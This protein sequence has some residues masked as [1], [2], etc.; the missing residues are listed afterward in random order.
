MDYEFFP[1]QAVHQALNIEKSMHWDI[2]DIQ[3]KSG[4]QN[5]NHQAHVNSNAHQT[6][7][8]ISI[9]VHWQKPRKFDNWSNNLGPDIY[10]NNNVGWKKTP[11]NDS[12][13]VKLE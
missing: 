6:C 12:H 1:Q 9:Q 2:A 5:K 4:Q 7:Y 3:T 10:Q 11:A 13:L 8:I